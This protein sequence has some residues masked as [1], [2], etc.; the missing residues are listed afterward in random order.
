MPTYEFSFPGSAAGLPVSITE[1]GVEVDTAT[2]PAATSAWGAVV[3]SANLPEGSYVG[4]AADARIFYSSRAPGVVNVLAS[5]AADVSDSDSDI[6]TAMSATFARGLD[7]T[8]LAGLT[9]WQEARGNALVRPVTITALGDSIT[10]GVGSDDN[11]ST[12]PIATVL[13][14]SWG[15]QLRKRLNAAWGTTDCAGW[16]AV[17]SPF[18]RAGLTNS[19]A[20][21][22][23][24]TGPLGSMSGGGVTLSTGDSLTFAVGSSLGV[25]TELDIWMWGST[26]GVSSPGIP[27]VSV[28]S[29]SKI[30]ASTGLTGNLVRSTVTG[31]AATTHEVVIT[32]GAASSYIFAVTARHSKG[33][34][35]NRIAISGSTSQDIGG[36]YGGSPLTGT[37]ITRNI[38]S[39]VMKGFS[40]LLIL[41]MGTNDQGNQVPLATYSANLQRAID[42]AVA[43]GGCVLLWGGPPDSTPGTPI[44]ED[45]YREVMRS[46]ALTNE[47]VAYTD[48]RDLFG[49]VSTAYTR[50]LFPSATTVHPSAKGHGLIANAVFELLNIP[51]YS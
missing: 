31:L 45:D 14:L 33:F 32:P 29:V 11:P 6:G 20:S 7:V 12:T 13:E 3:V 38:D 49:D 34:V 25:F 44:P 48:M 27:N 15:V 22:S 18:G 8:N 47:H 30:V 37:A 21:A 50:G 10:Y 2:A 26:S 5:V 46:L 16:I 19:G 51:R 40:D 35:Y 42:S 43:G 23:S 41:A 9:R 28:D 24:S 39:G 4:E 17:A 36:D 1:G